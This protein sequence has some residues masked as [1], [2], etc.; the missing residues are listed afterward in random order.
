MQLFG[1]SGAGYVRRRCGAALPQ[2]RHARACPGHPRLWFQRKDGRGAGPSQAEALP[3]LGWPGY[4]DDASSEDFAPES[5]ET[6][7]DVATNPPPQRTRHL[8]EAR[9]QGYCLTLNAPF[10]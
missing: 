8:A 4:D 6:V 9:F 7:K 1:E 5:P 3:S 2:I 10:V